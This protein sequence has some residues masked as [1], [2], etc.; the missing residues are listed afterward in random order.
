M[1]KKD[2]RGGGGNISIYSKVCA[3]TVILAKQPGSGDFRPTVTVVSRYSL[4]AIHVFYILPYDNCRPFSTTSRE[5]SSVSIKCRQ[6]EIDDTK[7]KRKTPSPTPPR[8]GRGDEKPGG[9]PGAQERGRDFN[10]QKK[11]PFRARIGW[12]ERSEA[13]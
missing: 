7:K 10:L 6:S 11:P 4:Y 13:Q 1:Q 12:G 5:K 3:R 2:I 8:A 9:F